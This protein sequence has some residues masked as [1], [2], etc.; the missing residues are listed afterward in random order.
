MKQNQILKI[1][2]FLVLFC[3]FV[4]C[5]IGCRYQAEQPLD[6]GVITAEPAETED[7]ATQKPTQDVM[8]K[9]ILNTR[10]KKIHKTSCETGDLILPENRKEYTGDIEELFRLGYTKCGNCF[11]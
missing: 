6:D 4:S 3:F 11:R 9:Y 10:S 1:I 2:S 7:K 8:P 5:F